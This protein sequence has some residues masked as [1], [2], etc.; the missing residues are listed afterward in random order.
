M[1]K[2]NKKV[3]FYKA[4]NGEAV[5]INLSVPALRKMGITPESKDVVVIYENDK[6]I[7]KKA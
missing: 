4:G 2:K 1:E 7:I 3:S 6:V 5:R